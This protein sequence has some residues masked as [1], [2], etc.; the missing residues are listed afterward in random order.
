MVEEK[1][2]TG[3]LFERLCELAVQLAGMEVSDRPGLLQALQPRPIGRLLD[4][5]GSAA[6]CTRPGARQLLFAMGMFAPRASHAPTKALPAL[7]LLAAIVG[8]DARLLASLEAG[9]GGGGGSRQAPPLQPRVLGAPL[10]PGYGFL[11]ALLW[12]NEE[13]APELGCGGSLVAPNVSCCGRSTEAG[14]RTGHRWPPISPGTL[15]CPAGAC[16]WC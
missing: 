10:G 11:A 9:G 16:R 1:P 15:P 6:H 12:P 13:G 4:P 3:R 5:A 14:C 2:V 7:L 8:L